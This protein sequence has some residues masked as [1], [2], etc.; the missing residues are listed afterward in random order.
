MAL[1]RWCSSKHC[2]DV[3]LGIRDSKTRAFTARIDGKRVV[4]CCGIGDFMLEDDGEWI[5]FIDR[6][7]T[8]AE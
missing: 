6:S 7:L 2:G 3:V 4:C 1:P 5:A 8:I